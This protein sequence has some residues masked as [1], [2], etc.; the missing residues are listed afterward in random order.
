MP[1]A[2]RQRMSAQEARAFSRYS[3]SNAGRVERALHCG[4]RAYQDV[5][6]YGRWRA[7]GFQVQRGQRA[8]KLP[9]LIETADEDDDGQPITRKRLWTGA[10]FCRH[11]VTEANGTTASAPSVQE[12]TPQTEPTTQPEPATLSQNAQVD[13]LMETWKEL[14]V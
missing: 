7:L 1:V 14:V 2:T 12:P 11:Q 8:V 6:T 5:F 13:R 9:I 3:P 10:V 4:C